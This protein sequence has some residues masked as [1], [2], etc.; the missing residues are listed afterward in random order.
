MRRG[1]KN[2][3]RPRQTLKNEKND[4]HF[5]FKKLANQ[6]N[7]LENVHSQKN[8][9]RFNIPARYF[10]NN[11]F[12]LESLSSGRPSEAKQWKE[13]MDKVEANNLSGCVIGWPSFIGT[14]R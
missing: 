5:S 10:D 4:D 6:L 7:A 9:D 12:F 13:L 2:K 3:W 11:Y 14:E 1:S 8:L